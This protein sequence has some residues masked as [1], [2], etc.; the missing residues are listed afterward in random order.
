M[1]VTAL[2]C[3]APGAVVALSGPL[4][5]GRSRIGGQDT[6]YVCRQFVCDAPTTDPEVLARQVR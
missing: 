6:A 3:I 1:H 2:A 5:E 4:C